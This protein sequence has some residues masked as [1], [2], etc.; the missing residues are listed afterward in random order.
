MPTC[1]QLIGVP[2]SGKSTW[3]S[4]QDWAKD[5]VVI[6]TDDHVERF[7]AER[8]ST[9]SEVFKEYMPRAVE[10]M[11]QDVI[12]ARKADKDIIWDQTSTTRASRARKFRM[13]PHYRHVA[14]V[15]PT[16]APKEL[17]RRLANRPGKDIPQHVVNGM[18]K[19]FEMPTEHEG[20]DEIWYV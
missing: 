4:Q 15:F 7:A 19:N 9:Y 5:C 2:G 14:V 17:M 6:S 8:G 10:M 18:I 13:L 1:F 12:A 16:P 11:A 20:F 3:I